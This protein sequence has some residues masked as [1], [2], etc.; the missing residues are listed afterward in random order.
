MRRDAVIRAP[1]AGRGDGLALR[2]ITQNLRSLCGST[3]RYGP[4]SYLHPA[5]QTALAKAIPP[6]FCTLL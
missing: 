2:S 3:V 4:S 6:A 1:G 5:I